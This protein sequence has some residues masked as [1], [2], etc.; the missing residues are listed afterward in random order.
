[1]YRTL[2]D[3]FIIQ[4]PA[5]RALISTRPLDGWRY[6]GMMKMEHSRFLLESR[7]ERKKLVQYFY[8]WVNRWFGS[9]LWQKEGEWEAAQL[10][11]TVAGAQTAYQT[12]PN[13]KKY[14]P[15]GFDLVLLEGR[16]DWFRIALTAPVGIS[17]QTMAEL[18]ADLA[19]DGAMVFDN[20]LV[21]I[22]KASLRAHKGRFS[23]LAQG[24]Y[25]PIRENI[26]L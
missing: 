2:M 16:E 26:S 23:I 13:A 21:T 12:P 20:R 19:A 11:A 14:L 7:E 25:A 5:G 1:M 17:L 4:L 22:D 10:A 24:R 18:C 15:E 6:E 8:E 3:R 9:F